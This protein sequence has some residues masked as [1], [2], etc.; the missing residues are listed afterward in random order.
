MARVRETA[1]HRVRMCIVTVGSGS[2]S[3]VARIGVSGK[4]G[5]NTVVEGL[6]PCAIS[7]AC[8]RRSA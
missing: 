6:V 3:T 4:G 8:K 2:S 7:N 5:R 1:F